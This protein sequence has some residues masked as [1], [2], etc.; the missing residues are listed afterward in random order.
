MTAQT[1]EGSL[2]D[3]L[4]K[5]RYPL[6]NYLS[7]QQQFVKVHSTTQSVAVPTPP[8]GWILIE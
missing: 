7:R 3:R 5:S 6:T 4:L 8:P 2:L 1:T